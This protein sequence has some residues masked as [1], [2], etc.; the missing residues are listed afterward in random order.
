M[1]NLG[2]LYQS[3]GRY[4]EAAPLYR[5]A[6]EAKERTLGPEHPKTLTSVNNLAWLRLEL[7]ATPADDFRRLLLSW[8]DPENWKH[9]WARLGLALCEGRQS[10]TF[11]P[12]EAVVTALVALLGEDHDR[13][14]TA[15]ARIQAVR[16]AIG[17]G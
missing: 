17:E 14:A 5:R 6:L 13:V 2:S 15:R 9:H 11:A 7:G 8:T 10:G 12:A 4:D 1:N 16:G 3:Q